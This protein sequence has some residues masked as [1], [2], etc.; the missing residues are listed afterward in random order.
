MKNR[1][2][3]LLLLLVIL[4]SL[5]ACTPKSEE[6]VISELSADNPSEEPTVPPVLDNNNVTLTKNATQLTTIDK[7]DLT[8]HFLTSHG[9]PEN[10]SV[11]YISPTTVIFATK[12][13]VL[14]A[15][16]ED[17]KWKFYIFDCWSFSGNGGDHGYLMR[18]DGGLLAIQSLNTNSIFLLDWQSGNIDVIGGKKM[19]RPLAWEGNDLYFGYDTPRYTG[20]YI[21]HSETGII[22]DLP[23]EDEKYKD[24]VNNNY[25]DDALDYSKEE[26]Q[27]AINDILMTK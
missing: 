24:I 21:Y 18:R 11:L 1:F 10:P 12:Y 16:L 22:E 15:R 4:L 13:D 26:R 3:C 20:L 14:V 8:E 5:T 23:L 6:T 9:F 27:K 25:L 7:S 19:L 17:S 2:L